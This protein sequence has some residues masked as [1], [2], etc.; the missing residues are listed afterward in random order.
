[1]QAE[2]ST[3]QIGRIFKSGSYFHHAD[4][5]PRGLWLFTGL[6]NTSVGQTGRIVP[7]IPE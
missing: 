6:V 3:E 1:M 7:I 5:P 2:K 4:I